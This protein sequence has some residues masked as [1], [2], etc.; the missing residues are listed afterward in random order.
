MGHEILSII[1]SLACIA[2]IG[3]IVGGFIIL[4]TGFEGI[5]VSKSYEPEVILGDLI[6][7]EDF[8]IEVEQTKGEGNFI[9]VFYIEKYY[10]N[11][12]EVGD[13]CKVLNYSHEMKDDLEVYKK[14]VKIA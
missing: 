5:I 12:L 6:D 2:G 9:K 11:N 1:G 3:L 10:Y 13:S 7:N 14:R 8:I 4:Y